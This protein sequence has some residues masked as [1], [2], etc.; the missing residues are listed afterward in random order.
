LG[1]EQKGAEAPSEQTSLGETHDLRSGNDQVVKH[2]DIDQPKRVYQS[3]RDELIGV[4][5]LSDPGWMGMTE[6]HSGRVEPQSFLDDFPWMH[7]RAINGAAKEL[8]ELDDAVSAVK[9]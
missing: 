7:R 1:I 9:E 4:R 6:D 2:P 3:A 8:D 5:W